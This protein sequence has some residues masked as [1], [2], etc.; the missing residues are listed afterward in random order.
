MTDDQSV[1]EFPTT[2][3]ISFGNGGGF[4]GKVHEY[5]LNEHGLL[6][7]RN[8]N[9]YTAKTQIDKTLCKQIFNS[10]ESLDLYSK[11]IDDPGNLYY[12]VS[13]TDSDMVI[14]FTWGGINQEVDPALR[15][16]YQLLWGLANR[17]VMAT[18]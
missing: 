7:K 2:K 14:P 6:E 1:I 10:I 8:G 17:K 3:T 11:R 16:F 4:S 13:I 15:N 18:Q 9:S 5:R 12:F